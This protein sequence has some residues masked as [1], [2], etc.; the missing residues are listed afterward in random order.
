MDR[1]PRPLVR[2]PAAMAAQELDLQVVERIEIGEAVADAPR[3]DRI[4]VE[5]RPL[6]RDRERVPD[7]RACSSAIR[8]KI[9]SRS[10]ASATELG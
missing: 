4:V 7:Q 2:L 1:P 3:E 8:A 6:A 9:D 5:E 10:A